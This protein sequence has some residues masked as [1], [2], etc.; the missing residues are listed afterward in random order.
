MDNF[1]GLNFMTLNIISR[2]GSRSGRDHAGRYCIH[3]DLKLARETREVLIVVLRPQ[4]YVSESVDL[5][6]YSACRSTS[7]NLILILLSTLLL[8][9]IPITVCGK[10]VQSL[11]V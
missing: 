4:G 8:D 9:R 11:L 7:F 10:I 6:R 5:D 1:L 3:S 2:A